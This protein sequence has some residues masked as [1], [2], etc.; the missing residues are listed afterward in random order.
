MCDSLN[1]LFMDYHPLGCE[2]GISFSKDR[3]LFYIYMSDI[4]NS[5]LRISN[6]LH[7]FFTYK[8]STNKIPH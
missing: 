4:I 2:D 8:H 7:E 5:K 6:N 1:Y 3:N